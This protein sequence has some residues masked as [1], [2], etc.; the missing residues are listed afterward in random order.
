MGREDGTRG[1]AASRRLHQRRSSRSRGGY[2]PG[3]VSRCKHRLPGFRPVCLVAGVAYVLLGGSI[4]VRGGAASLAEFGVPAA[5]LAS[6]HY[7]DAIWWV[8]V[9]MIV[10][11]LIML[12][13]GAF[14]EGARLRRGFSRLMLA[15]HAYYLFLDVRSSDTALGNGLYQGPASIAPAIIVLVVLLLFVHPSL[16]RDAGA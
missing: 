14:G 16:C 8:Y 12:V 11:G 3:V 5:T 2:A 7:A 10:I 1:S 13:V 15:A 9:H 6:P 4:L